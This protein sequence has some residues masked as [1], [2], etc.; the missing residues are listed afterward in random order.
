MRLSSVPSYPGNNYRYPS[1]DPKRPMV[2]LWNFA[3]G[4]PFISFSTTQA[5]NPERFTLQLYSLSSFPTRN[6]SIVLFWVKEVEAWTAL[7]PV[8]PDPVKWNVSG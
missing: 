3:M 2:R 4:A 6:L 5:S 1:C 8:Q 7:G